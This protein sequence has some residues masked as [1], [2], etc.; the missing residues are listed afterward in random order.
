M[1]EKN[2]KSNELSLLEVV[3]EINSNSKSSPRSEILRNK[4]ISLIGKTKD[5]YNSYMRETNDEN[6]EMFVKV[7]NEKNTFSVNF[8]KAKDKNSLIDVIKNENLKTDDDVNKEFNCEVKDD[9]NA[10]IVKFS[11]K[12][13]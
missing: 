9:N 3:S 12:K 13:K 11:K 1:N 6:L 10:V 2:K 5:I 8:D 7:V 4:N